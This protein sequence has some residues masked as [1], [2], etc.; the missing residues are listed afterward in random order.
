[1]HKLLTLLVLLVTSAFANAHH[2]HGK[3]LTCVAKSVYHEGR[4]LPSKHWIKIA[5]VAY[6]RQT[7]FHFYNYGAKS[8]HLC[9]IVKSKQYS[10]RSK[11]NNRMYE[12]E[13][14]NE[15]LKTLSKSNWHTSTNA[16]YFTTTKQKVNYKLNWRK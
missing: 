8:K 6:N 9:D 3:E 13:L 15:I 11:L 10:T 7:N 12:T 4:S 16:L 5:N 14:Y 2:I 1:M